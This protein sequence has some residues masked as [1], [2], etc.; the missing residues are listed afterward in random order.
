MPAPSGVTCSDLLGVPTFSLIK[1]KTTL[2][3]CDLRKY[4]PRKIKC[5][6]VV[7]CIIA[8]LGLH[9]LRTNISNG[10]CINL[11]VHSLDALWNLIWLLMKSHLLSRP[12]PT[13]RPQ[14]CRLR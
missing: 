10:R 14:V 11:Q 9:K 2:C 3:L 8:L 5:V 7:L 4:T 1:C 12:T 6:G 13:T